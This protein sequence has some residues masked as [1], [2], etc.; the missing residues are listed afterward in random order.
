MKI[1]TTRIWA[2]AKF[3][4][5]AERV[6]QVPE[7]LGQYMVDSQAARKLPDDYHFPTDDRGLLKKRSA[8]AQEKVDAAK[9]GNGEAEAADFSRRKK[10]NEDATRKLE[11]AKAV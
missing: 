6:L 11:G 4:I 1:L 2:S 7:K 10:E 5:P 3:N 9:L 8:E